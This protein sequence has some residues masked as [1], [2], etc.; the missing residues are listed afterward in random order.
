MKKIQK[1]I[2]ATLICAAFTSNV[3]AAKKN[4][5][6]KTIRIGT[7]NGESGNFDGIF[8]IARK[9][10][11]FNEE[12]EK[13]GYEPEFLGFKN[14]VAINEAFLSGELDITSI[15]DVPALTGFA[16]SVPYKWVGVNSAFHNAAV[17]TKKNSGIKTAQ[18]LQGKQ[19][20]LGIGTSP[21]FFFESY[22]KSNKVQKDKVD[23]V[24]IPNSAEAVTALLTGN[25]DAIAVVA[26]SAWA[27]IADGEAELLVDSKD[28]PEWTGQQIILAS[29]KIIKKDPNVVV[30][31]LKAV[32]RAKEA[33]AADPKRDYIT[34][35]GQ[36][37]GKHP[38]IGERIFNLDGGKFE[39]LNGVIDESRIVREQ[40]VYDF[41][42]SIKR[43]YVKKDLHSF[44]DDSFYK[45]AVNELKD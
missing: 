29:N 4:A 14:G 36:R 5:K 45:K 26:M 30:A 1:L 28:Y 19:V 20:A 32:I 16:N 22:L 3:F 33:F 17:V 6:P 37:L 39:N 18:D 23:I 7:S 8:G 13:I 9:L 10:G 2:V 31:V 27:S 34:L 42:Y 40:S 41:L 38:E 35:S 44:A 24:N 21:Q 43:I 25:V 11:Y 12:L 15:G